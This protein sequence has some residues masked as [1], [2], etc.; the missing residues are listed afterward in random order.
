MLLCSWKKNIAQIIFEYNTFRK[1]I[2]NFDQTPL[3]FT[4]PNKTIFLQQ[5]EEIVTIANI[6]DECQLQEYFV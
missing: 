5:V 6:D 3:Y 1:M 4:T 2:I